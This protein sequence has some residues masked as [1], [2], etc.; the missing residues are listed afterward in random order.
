MEIIDEPFVN[1]AKNLGIAESE[2]FEKMK[3]CKDIGVMRRFAA[4]LVIGKSVLLQM[5]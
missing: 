1:A 2:L 3:Y 5:G 4:I